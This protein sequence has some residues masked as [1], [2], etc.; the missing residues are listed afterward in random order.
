MP[1]PLNSS[2]NRDD[3]N[4]VLLARYFAGEATP[5][6]RREVD[7]WVAADSEHALMVDSLREAWKSASRRGRSRATDVDAGWLRMRARVDAA[8]RTS[9]P[10]DSAVPRRA[11][12]GARWSPATLRIAAGLVLAVGGG[13]VAR[14]VVL[15]RAGRAGKVER[16]FVTTAGEHRTLLLDDSSEV[17]LGV[18][19]TLT[20]GAGFGDGVRELT[21]AGEALFR[22]RHDSTRPF[23]VHALG[24]VTEDVG[25]EFAIRA[26]HDSSSADVVRVVVTSGSVRVRAEGGADS[27]AVVVRPGER[28]IATPQGVPVVSAAADTTRLLAFARGDLVFDDVPMTRVAEDLERWYGVQVTFGSPALAA[29]HL[30]AAFSGE[31]V[32]EVLRVI[33]LSVGARFDHRDR[34]VTFRSVGRNE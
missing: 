17:V 3:A 22:V 23:R 28:A 14:A 26:Y 19:S 20:V 18:A 2:P 9:H 21:L 4:W 32:D 15:S 11:I 29:R 6:E 30:T 25:T 24:A 31:P 8:G 27:D 33:A 13:L 5:E 34:D 1:S 16:S 12:V 10:G 7:E